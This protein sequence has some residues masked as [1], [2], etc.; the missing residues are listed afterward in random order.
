MSGRWCHVQPKVCHDG[1]DGAS[2]WPMARSISTAAKFAAEQSETVMRRR[3]ANIHLPGAAHVAHDD[4]LDG[5][6]LRPAAEIAQ[7]LDA[8]GID[9]SKRIVSRCNGGGPA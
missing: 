8:E 4:L 7:L 3:P 5:T 9:G 1:I 6:H 2:Q